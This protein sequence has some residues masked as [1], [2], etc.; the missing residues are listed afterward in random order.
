MTEEEIKQKE[1]YVN[2]LSVKVADLKLENQAFL[3]QTKEMTERVKKAKEEALKVEADRNDLM[4]QLEELR[5]SKQALQ[6]AIKS[7][8]EEKDRLD[9]ETDKLKKE[10]DGMLKEKEALT[11]ELKDLNDSSSEANVELKKRAELLAINEATLRDIEEQLKLKEGNL[12]KREQILI[13]QARN[14]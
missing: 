3:D 5:Q 2:A 7:Y 12:E 8:E 13:L 1:L 11:R 9:K 4:S 14:S 10:I 6:G